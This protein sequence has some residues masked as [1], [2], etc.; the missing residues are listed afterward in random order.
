MKKIL[1]SLFLFASIAASAQTADEIVQ[2]Y[3]AAMGGLDGFKKVQTAK[4]TATV[5]V[6]GM[7]LPATIQVINGR[8]FRTDVEAMGQAV[9]NSYKDGKGW[10]INPFAG[11]ET[12]TDVEGTEL[13]SMKAQSSLPGYLMDYKSLGHTIELKGKETLEGV[14]TWK[15]VLTNKDDGKPTT[16][17]IIVA[18]NMLLRTVT[19]RDVQGESVEVETWYSDIKEFG[20]LKF[21]M[22]KTQKM[23]GQ[24][25]Q[26]ISYTNIELN[27]PVDEKIFDK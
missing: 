19:T 16:Y 11:M 24:V 18:D 21:Y 27:V 12:A 4:F 6:Q 25:F 9:V 20:G 1:F 17:N 15:I 10:S 23:N 8:A 13:L 2:K 26:T 3:A 7:D 5:A 22:T 14:P